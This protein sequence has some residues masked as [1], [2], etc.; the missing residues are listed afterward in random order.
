MTDD[1]S[2]NLIDSLGRKY[3]WWRPVDGQAFPDDR[4]L[5]QVMNLGT[6]DDILTLEK[7]F[8]QARLAA[9]M[10]HADPGWFNDRSWEFWRGRLTFSTGIMIPATAPRRAF[11]AATS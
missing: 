1:V 4:V 5:A 2:K 9:I 7:V 6:Y 10:V 11:D 8:G 3:L